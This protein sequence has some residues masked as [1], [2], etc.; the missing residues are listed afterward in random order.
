MFTLFEPTLEFTILNNLVKLDCTTPRS[1]SDIIK[2][3][4]RE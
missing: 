3:Q 2:E 4:N 1:C